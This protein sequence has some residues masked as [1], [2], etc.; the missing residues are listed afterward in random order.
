MKWRSEK[1]IG[2]VL[3]AVLLSGVVFVGAASG[4]ARTSRAETAAA[5]A[6]IGE[7]L[8][9]VELGGAAYTFDHDS[10]GRIDMAIYPLQTSM[11]DL[12]T[13]YTTLEEALAKNQVALRESNNMVA[14]RNNAPG[15]YPIVAQMGGYGGRS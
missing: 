14:S 1:R 12:K 3:L 15:S 5:Q 6:T 9:S 8:S 7:F 11:A 13:S 10:D 2:G 4:A